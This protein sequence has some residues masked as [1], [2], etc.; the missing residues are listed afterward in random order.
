MN[1]IK[2]GNRFREANLNNKCFITVDGTDFRILEPAPF[3]PKW[4]SHKFKGAG[5]RYEVAVSIST[6]WIVWVNGPFPCGDYPD[7]RIV[8]EALVSKLFN[9]EY[10]IADGGYFDG[11]Q[12][13]VTPTGRNEISDR[14]KGKARARHETINGRF[15]RWAVLG[16]VFRHNLMKHGKVFRAI[17]NLTQLEIRS[18][19]PV[20]HVVYR[21]DPLFE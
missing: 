7:L 9:W 10:Y 15:K 6:G 14:M 5:V 13:S 19:S 4:F 16:N 1:L 17:A 11:N 3:N 18:T 12:Y 21:E 2:F 20:F 8:R